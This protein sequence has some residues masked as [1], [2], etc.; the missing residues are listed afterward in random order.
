MDMGNGS[1]GALQQY[2]A[3]E[4]IDAIL[5]SHLHADHCLDACAFVVWH[6]YSERSAGPVPLFGPAGTRE[7]LATAYERPE[8]DL[9]DVFEFHTLSSNARER[10][11]I[12]AVA[13]EAPMI[14]DAGL[15]IGGLR[16]TFARTNHPVETYAIR[17]SGG[18][19]SVTYSADTGVCAGLVELARGTDL[20]LCESAQPDGDLA[21]PPNLHL[22]GF[23]AGEHAAAAGVGRLVLTHIPPW[24]DAR[25][26][27]EAAMSVFPATELAR[28]GAT[29]DL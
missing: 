21:Y 4:S 16:L 13:P 11:R 19:A 9:A 2:S 8:S 24:V 5:L 7:R 10:S 3:L 22:T 29:Y 28:P 14:M 18:K 20:L 25:A 27:V 6:R 12:T 17:V 26:Q 15:Q 23:Q 1:V